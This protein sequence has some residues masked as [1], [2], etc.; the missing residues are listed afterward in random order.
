VPVDLGQVGAFGDRRG[1]PPIVVP[2]DGGPCRSRG[3]PLAGSQQRQPAGQSVVGKRLTQRAGALGDVRT[4][5]GMQGDDGMS[6][7]DPGARAA[8]SLVRVR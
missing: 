7:Q 2:P 3:R 8:W 6:A 1:A 5:F 4:A